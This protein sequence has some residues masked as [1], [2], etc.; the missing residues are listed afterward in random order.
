MKKIFY[1]L[2]SVSMLI[3][4]VTIQSCKEDTTPPKIT[5]IGDKEIIIAKGSTYAD[6][7]ATADDDKDE[8]VN[9]VS[10]YG[11]TNPDM[12]TAGAYTIT[13]TAQDRNANIATAER[14]VYV[15]WTGIQV[16]F[17]YSVTDTSLIDTLSYQSIVSY[18]IQNFFRAYI[19][20]LENGSQFS[21]SVSIDLKGNSFTIPSQRPDGPFSQ[22]IV[23]GSG[24]ITSVPPNIV[25]DV[26]YVVTDTIPPTSTLARHAIFF[27]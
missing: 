6:L 3:C 12:N 1:L 11:A 25:W 23:S 26:H 13:Y 5:I 17:T 14:K 10:D 4:I 8:S 27:Y 20:N 15:T 22:Y 18:T 19:S 7:G 2:L 24:T 9:I 16:A 21:G